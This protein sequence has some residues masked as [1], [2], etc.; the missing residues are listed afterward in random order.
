MYDFTFILP[1][2]SRRPIGGY[3]IV[4]EYCNRLSDLGYNVSIIHLRKR[5]KSKLHFVKRVIEN[6]L[7]KYIFGSEV[8]WFRLAIGIKVQ[9]IESAHILEDQQFES[10]YYVA[11]AWDT[12]K[13]TKKIA[14]FFN[15]YGLYLIQ[16]Y[17]TWDAEEK[18]IIQTY[19]LGLRNIAIAKWLQESV[20]NSGAECYFVPNAF[21]FEDFHV[22]EPPCSRDGKIV[23]TMFHDSP[24]KGFKDVVSACEIVKEKYPETRFIAFGAYQ[25]GEYLP[26]WMSFH[27]APSKERLRNLYNSSSIFLSGSYTEGWAL[28]PSEAMQCGCALVATDIPGHRDFSIHGVNALLSEPGNYQLMAEHIS[29]LLEN[30][31]F[32]IRLA[33]SGNE[34]IQNYT[35]SKTISRFLD[36]CDA[37]SIIRMDKTKIEADL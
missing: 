9:E 21:D 34:F 17:E 19:H 18:E 13:I 7:H 35:W 3:K 25:P 32:R 15:A 20:K 1:E 31:S 11:T 37:A 23:L 24:L 5:S 8:V 12:A 36:I 6:L 27:F 4:Y 29:L 10:L 22:V 33:T 2:I 26:E 16:G 28:P 14:D 30:P